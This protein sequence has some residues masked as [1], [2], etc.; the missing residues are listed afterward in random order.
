MCNQALNLTLKHP[1][2]SPRQLAQHSFIS[3]WLAWCGSVTPK[4]RLC[5]IAALAHCHDLSNHRDQGRYLYLSLT[6]TTVLFFAQP[7]RPIKSNWVLS[8][9]HWCPK[10]LK[11][12]LMIFPSIL[13]R[14]RSQTWL[15]VIELCCF[16]ETNSVCTILFW[17]LMDVISML[18]VNCCNEW[19][20]VLNHYDLSLYVETYLKSFEISGL[21]GLWELKYRNLITSVIVFVLT[22]L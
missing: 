13:K 7:F 18:L 15:G 19:C 1:Q 11:L 21:S 9:L 20:V 5:C 22:F 3:C 12:S 17:T 14:K 2:S 4:A 10:A 8:L 16:R 6:L